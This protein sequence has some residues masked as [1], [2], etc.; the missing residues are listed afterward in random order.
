MS[1]NVGRN[2]AFTWAGAPV[3]GVRAKGLRCNGT[4]VDVTS[5]DDNGWREL[6][7]EAGQNEVNITIGGVTKDDRLAQAWASGARTA[8]AVI[9]MPNGRSVSGIFYLQ[10]YNEDMPYQD[11]ITFE[12]E[13]LS[14][15]EVEFEFP[16]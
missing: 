11:A 5:D 16:S 9:T 6:L 10:S 2:A 8:E 14:T 15:S 12:A 3:L 13:L 7:D 1:G 4:A